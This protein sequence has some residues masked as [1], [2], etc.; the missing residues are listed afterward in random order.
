MGFFDFFRKKPAPIPGVTESAFECVREG[1]TIRG[2]EYR[3]EGENLPIAIVSHGF[4][5][6]QDT[7]RHYCK[8]LASIG[9]VAYCF[10]FCGGSAPGKGASDGASTDMSVLTE[11]KDLE[12]VIDYTRSLPYTSDTLL[13]MGCSQGGFVSG[14]TAVKPENQVSKLVLFYPALC[15]PDD[16]RAGKMLF[17][18]FDPENIPDMINCGPMKLGGCYPR[19][20]IKMDSCAEISPYQGPVLIVHGTKDKIVDV[21]YSRKAAAAYEKT[22]PNRTRLCIIEDGAHGFGKKHDAHAIEQLKQFAK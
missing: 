17:A 13:L 12:A 11:V 6:F 2:T 18:R 21:E 22:A 7:V 19:D 9:Y 16:A 3:P 4:M 20:V 10:D 5:G 15:I 8:A 1:L 14:L